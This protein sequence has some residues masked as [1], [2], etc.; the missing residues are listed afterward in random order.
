MLNQAIVCFGFLGYKCRYSAEQKW[1]YVFGRSL[2]SKTTLI[3]GGVEGAWADSPTYKMWTF[4]LMSL[5]NFLKK[6]AQFFHNFQIDV[7]SFTHLQV[8]YFLKIG[9]QRAT[10]PWGVIR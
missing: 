5:A 1:T 9:T 8:N 4:F 6:M 2:W 10:V 7:I 3:T